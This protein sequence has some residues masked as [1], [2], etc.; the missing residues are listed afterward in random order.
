MYAMQVMEC[1]KTF[2]IIRRNST[3]CEEELLFYHSCLQF[4]V[5]FNK[6]CMKEY[7][8]GQEDEDPSDEDITGPPVCEP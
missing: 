4:M 2:G 6:H 5:A 3:M 7:I 1:I 8:D